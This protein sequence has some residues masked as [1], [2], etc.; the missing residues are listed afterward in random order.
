MFSPVQMCILLVWE[1]DYQQEG[2][3]S[4]FDSDIN[5]LHITMFFNVSDFWNVM[6]A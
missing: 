6:D 2:L 1:K 5:T 3:I 4:N